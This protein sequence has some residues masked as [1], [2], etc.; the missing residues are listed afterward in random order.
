MQVMLGTPMWTFSGLMQKKLPKKMP[1]SYTHLTLVKRVDIVPLEVIIR[2]IAAGSFSKRYGVEEG[3]VFAEPTIEISYKNDA[4][5]EDVYKRQGQVG[6][7]FAGC[8]P[9]QRRSKEQMPDM[10]WS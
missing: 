5:G 6:A 3:T 8:H 1:V 9:V 7:I 2:N 10:D 4:L